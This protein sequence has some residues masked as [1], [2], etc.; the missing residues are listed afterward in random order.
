[1]FL[2]ST[3]DEPSPL[4][5]CDEIPHGRSK[6][7]F[8]SP[9]HMIRVSI[10]TVPKSKKILTGVLLLIPLMMVVLT[11]QASDGGS[12]RK[13]IRKATTSSSVCLRGTA[14]MPF[15][16]SS[17]PFTRTRTGSAWRKKVNK[18]ASCNQMSS[19]TNWFRPISRPWS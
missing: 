5:S 1:M 19:L 16:D 18:M 10:R 12:P 11:R 14:R 3:E 4:L 8:S 15:R 17:A 6:G 7:W 13:K 9:R 2:V